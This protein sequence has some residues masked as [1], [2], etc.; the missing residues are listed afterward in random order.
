M[1][2]HTLPMV[3]WALVTLVCLSQCL[4]GLLLMANG[5]DCWGSNAPIRDGRRKAIGWLVPMTGIAIV[6]SLLLLK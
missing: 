2:V 5:P 6:G 1:T 3:L 4:H